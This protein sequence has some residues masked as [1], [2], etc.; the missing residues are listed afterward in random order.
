MT[1]RNATLDDAS[2]ISRFVTDLAT[3]H[4]AP[5][6]TDNGL[7]HLL[8]SMNLESTQARIEDGWLH[9]LQ[10]SDRD[11]LGLIVVKPPAH[12]Y[13]LFVDTPAQRSGVGRRLFRVADERTLRDN[14]IR[15]ETVNSS[16]NAIDAYRRL[17]FV[18]SGA[19][20]DVEGVRF[21]PMI[22]DSGEQ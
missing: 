15:I 9:I 11:I 20:V 16:L 1:L 12:L 4:I 17:G 2:A 22:R 3:E 6:L 18:T 21:Q 5:S 8:A 14:G 7:S 10:I 19:V 13:H